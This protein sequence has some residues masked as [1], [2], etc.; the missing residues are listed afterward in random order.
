MAGD[1]WFVDTNVLV[2]LFDSDSPAK[3]ATARQLLNDNAE[4]IILST[5]V[6]GEFYVTVTRKL[7]KPLSADR[8][9]EALEELRTFRIRSIHTE[10]TL[11][12][13]RRSVSSR[14]SYW[15]ALI[16]ESALEAGANVLLTEDLQHGQTFADLRVVNPFKEHA[17]PAG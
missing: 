16:V 6:L 17:T 12:A 9:M 13:V 14:L 15:D 10:L 8:A 3:K 11:S 7:G 5:Q 4:N 1:P 2:Y